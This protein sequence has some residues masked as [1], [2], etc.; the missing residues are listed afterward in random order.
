MFTQLFTHPACLEHDTGEGHPECADR[1]RAIL[2]ALE[3]E[4][5]LHLERHEAPLGDVDM[6]KKVHKPEYVDA[7]LNKV[8]EKGHAFVDPD[9]LLSPG[10]KEAMLR[11]VGGVCS[12]IDAVLTGQAPNAFVATRPPGHHAEHSAAMGFCFFNNAAVGARYAQ[13]TFRLRKIAVVDFDVHHGNGTE[14]LFRFDPDLFYASSHQFPA[15]PGT[16]HQED[17]GQFNNICN[18]ELPPGA[19]GKAFRHAYE[20][21]ILPALDHFKPEL[22]IISAGFD[23][24][25]RDPLAQCRLSTDDFIWVTREIKKIAAEHCR[26]RIVSVLEGGYDLGAL[27]ASVA[28]HVAVLMEH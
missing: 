13:E 20:H 26:G 8:P 17:R 16:G 27:A 6:I 9:T 4:R 7:I 23:A 18:A 28:V 19:D 12:A 5:F 1:L 14:E 21:E 15:Y 10:S 3:H 11:S 24:H 25:G 2:Q 22:I